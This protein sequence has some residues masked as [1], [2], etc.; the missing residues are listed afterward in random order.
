MSDAS[1]SGLSLRGISKSF[2]DT[3]V[4]KGVSLEIPPGEFVTLLGPS[5]C[6]KSTLLR[7]IAGLEVQS[8]GSVWIDGRSVDA[9]RAKQRDIAMVFQSYALYPHMTVYQ[10]IALPLRMRRL[11]QVQRLP[12]VGGVAPGLTARQKTIDAD[13]RSTAA[14]LEI[15]HLLARKPGQLSGGQRQR[16]A[17]ARALV[18]RPTVFLMDEPLSNLDA[19]LRV[20][21]R[22]E[23]KA[24]HR[25]L[26]I[27]FVY[28]THDQAEAMTMSDRVA[29]MMEGELVQVATPTDIYTQ[30]AD[31]RVGTFIGAPAINLLTGRA[32][33]GAVVLPTANLAI[34]HGLEEGQR[35]T[36]GL[37]PEDLSVVDRATPGAFSGTVRDIE[38]MG[39]DLYAHVEMPGHDGLVVIRTDPARRA[40]LNEAGT[41]FFAPRGTQR[42]VF[43][44]DGRRIGGMANMPVGA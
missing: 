12:W 36:V 38:H 24:L 19:K 22:T 11:N 39:A 30:P 40:A 37:R 32:A 18:R 7:I 28:V 16:V 34:D 35:V 5:G 4:L 20:Q 9:V 43:G 27:T 23:I 17:V 10:N 1:A 2:G 8:A 15:D 3:P 29:V 42:L 13:V 25:R 33:K 14:A 21:M 41:V 44:A 6:G 26:G 31:I